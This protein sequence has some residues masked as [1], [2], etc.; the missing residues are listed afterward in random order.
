[1]DSNVNST[2][3]AT[4]GLD[5][6]AMKALAFVTT[7]FLPPTFVAVSM[8]HPIQS[9]MELTNLFIEQ[10]LFSMSMFDWQA[11]AKAQSSNSS[12]GTDVVSKYFGVYWAVSLPLTIVVLSTWR[13]WWHRE[14]DRYRRKYPHVH[15]DPDVGSN[16]SNK[17][18]RMMWKRKVSGDIEMLE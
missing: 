6:V 1:M 11:D 13:T 3:A 15:L 8:I 7:L 16:V 4:T 10:T 5:S 12:E 18:K 2:I 14:K 17:L 9:T